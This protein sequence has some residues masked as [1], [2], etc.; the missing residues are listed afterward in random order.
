MPDA[1][2]SSPRPATVWGLVF[3]VAAALALPAQARTEPVP[4]PAVRGT[5]RLV[6]SIVDDAARLLAGL[7]VDA[8]SPLQPLSATPALQV[9]ART[10]DAVWK[11]VTA[12]RVAVE[13]AFAASELFDLGGGAVF[14]PFGGPDILNA[15]ALMPEA[16]TYTLLGLE[17]IGP[18]P[19][20]ALVAD[21]P[22]LIAV[23]RAMSYA[24]RHNLFITDAMETQVQ[25]KVGV[26]GLLSFFLVRSGYTIVDARR[27]TLA[28]DG[29]V[30]DDVGVD[31]DDPDH[32]HG[33]EFVVRRGEHAP[34]QR[35]RYFSGNINDEFFARVQ[36][37]TTHLLSLGPLT[38]LIK[39][40]SYLLYYPAFDDVRALV[41]ARSRAIVTDTSGLPFHYLDTP[42]W[43]LSL[44]GT[45]LAPIH[46]FADRCQPDLKLALHQR[47][48]GS[49]PFSYG[50][51]YAGHNHV[52]V[53]RRAAD[54][55]VDAPVFDRSKYT[56]DNTLC[57][58]DRV[59]VLR[60][61]P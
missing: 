16:S 7:P 12:P 40:A 6:R 43:Q 47:A 18:L 60:M 28:V 17:P 5:E 34:Q 23:Q 58:D 51:S 46:A 30:V 35:V 14:Y 11:K 61:A 29:A 32:V 9:H 3:V 41:L 44:Y 25:G 39:A 15:V 38:T 45:Y 1:G 19:S 37:L 56:G 20:A 4:P 50:Y 49:L 27:V 13:R 8:R 36:G 42:A 10:V 57:R 59:R 2:A 53:A 21:G 24:L 54:R 26:A 52:V 31:V 33:I 55:V 22:T 48:K